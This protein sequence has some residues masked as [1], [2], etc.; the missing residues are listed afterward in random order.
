MKASY[1]F[2]MHAAVCYTRKCIVMSIVFMQE[3]LGSWSS[4]SIK[5]FRGRFGALN[6]PSQTETL[7][8]RT[9]FNQ[10]Y[11]PAKLHDLDSVTKKIKFR[12]DFP[13]VIQ[14]TIIFFSIYWSF[15]SFKVVIIREYLPRGTS[16]FVFVWTKKQIYCDMSV[17]SLVRPS[18]RPER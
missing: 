13:W 5:R 17:R 1:L 6:W 4:S 9:L 8:F 3:L 2:H 16:G 7:N 14:H 15:Q 10:K 18:L 11:H 12:K